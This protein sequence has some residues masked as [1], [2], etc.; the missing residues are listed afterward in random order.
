LTSA[1]AELPRKDTAPSAG[2]VSVADMIGDPPISS[3]DQ[4]SPPISKDISPPISKLTDESIDTSHEDI[5][6]SGACP[7]SSA[8]SVSAIF[9]ASMARASFSSFLSASKSE[10]RESS[11]FQLSFFQD[12][13][14][15]SPVPHEDVDHREGSTI[16]WTTS[17]E[18]SIP[19]LMVTGVLASRK[20]LSKSH[21]F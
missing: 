3:E 20:R 2:I 5:D 21:I 7:I 19:S 9:G 12:P 14:P 13:V 17:F 1:G 8:I 15:S 16:T 11:F 10:T 4:P 6:V 18:W